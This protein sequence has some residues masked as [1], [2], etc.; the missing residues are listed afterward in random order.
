ML[1]PYVAALKDVTW[2]LLVKRCYGDDLIY[3]HGLLTWWD[4][5]STRVR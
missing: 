3:W 2:R 5:M 4:R 1:V